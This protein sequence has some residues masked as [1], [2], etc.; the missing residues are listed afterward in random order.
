M[1]RPDRTGDYCL[2]ALPR[3]VTGYVPTFNPPATI[4]KPLSGTESDGEIQVSP[5][6]AN[7]TN[8][9]IWEEGRSSSGMGEA[10]RH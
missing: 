8:A 6:S 3:D 7:M 9:P 1:A 2:L 10:G 4:H 5:P